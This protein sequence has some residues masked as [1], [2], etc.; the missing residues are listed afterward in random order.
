MSLDGL[1]DSPKLSGSQPL[2]ILLVDDEPATLQLVRR[3]LQA[4]GH[5]IYEAIDGEQAVQMFDAVHPDLVL[6]DIVIPK[7]DGLEVLVELRQRDKMAG[8]IMVSALTSEQLAVKS[9]LGGADDYV[10][11]PF[12]LKAILLSI[13]QVMDKVRLRRRNASLQNE[14]IAANQR[15][16]QYM[17]KP[18]IET[19]LNSP[20]PPQLGGVRETVTVLF[21]DFANFTPLSDVYKRQ[22]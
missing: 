5:D 14:L 13:R 19:L 3:L 11:K 12:R 18:L 21:L 10:N 17:A 22:V 16:R 6:L 20:L 8:I 15:L 4:D 2:R 7:K 1:L 9:M